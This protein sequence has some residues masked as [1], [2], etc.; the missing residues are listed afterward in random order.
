MQFNLILEFINVINMTL[1]SIFMAVIII[2]LIENP[3]L[4]TRKNIAFILTFFSLSIFFFSNYLYYSF[5][6]HQI[7]DYPLV[8]GFLDFLLSA[9]VF[10][11]LIWYSLFLFLESDERIYYF[12]LSF[13]VIGLSILGVIVVGLILITTGDEEI[14]L[15]NVLA[16]GGT[17]VGSILGSITLL[18][19]GREKLFPVQDRLLMRRRNIRYVGVGVIFV[20]IGSYLQLSIPAMPE[21]LIII[22]IVMCIAV[23]LFFIGITKTR[24][25]LREIS[26]R[27]IEN[28][29]D[30]LREIDRLKS[31]IIDVS[32]H[33]MR[34]PIA[35]IKGHFDLLIADENNHHMAL[36]AR[37]KSFKAINRNID[38]IE[39]SLANIYDFSSIRRELFD[40]QFENSNLIPVL[41]STINDMSS[42][43][44]QK[45]LTISFTNE[46]TLEPS[47]VR[48]D[49]VRISQVLRNL[50]ENAI[51]YSSEGEI[52]VHLEETNSEYVVSVIDPGVG[53]DKDSMETIFDPFKG[54]NQ[55]AIDVKGLGLGLFICKNIIEGHHGRIWA[56]SEGKGSQFYFSLPKEGN[57]QRVMK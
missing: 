55:S 28:Q 57:E 21:L 53:I 23:I 51:K 1:C 10:L 41:N 50:L 29:L 56:T 45:G 39:R 2:Y 26:V 38:R 22:V 5:E 52:K 13:F 17:I 48:I 42:L 36:E 12:I 24:E 11:C 43:A 4:R 18:K 16:I 40:F 54:K 31:Q 25:H 34:T 44:E 33:E 15:Y 6:S 20:S 47:F 7:F 32:S 27:I 19:A 35:V 3:N 37:E 49:P 9:S 30:E 14:F 46:I 8:E